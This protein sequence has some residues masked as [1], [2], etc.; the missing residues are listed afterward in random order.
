MDLG[1]PFHLLRS[2]LNKTTATFQLLH[3]VFLQPTPGCR[4]ADSVCFTV[5]R[6]C[7]TTFRVSLHVLYHRRRV[8]ASSL[9]HDLILP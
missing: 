2:D 3:L 1:L 4:F 7:H 9:F 8:S 5:C 6:L